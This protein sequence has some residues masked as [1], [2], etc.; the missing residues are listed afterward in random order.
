MQHVETISNSEAAKDVLQ[1]FLPDI[2]GTNSVQKKIE[3]RRSKLKLDRKQEQLRSTARKKHEDLVRNAR[4]QQIWNSR[5]G[6]EANDEV[7]HEMCHLY[8][9][10]RVDNVEDNSKNAEK[11]K[12]AGSHDSLEDNA[13]LCNYLPLLR[14]FIPSAAE[15]IEF[16]VT[17]SLLKEENYVYDLYTV[18]DGVSGNAEHPS[19]EYPLVQVDHEDDYYDGPDHSDYETDD[20]NAEDNPNND[21]PDEESSEDE[22]HEEMDLYDEDVERSQY[23][24]EE[25]YVSEEDEENHRWGHR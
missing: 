2:G 25:V 7:L 1:S 23:E 14:E 3:E 17:S 11:T 5:R 12:S 16:G 9:V 10:V 8:D 18:E 21:Y 19:T 13:I 15:E 4:F 24:D 20:S 6:K 22:G